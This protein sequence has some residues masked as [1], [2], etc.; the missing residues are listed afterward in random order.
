[1]KGGSG[2]RGDDG[3]KNS[4]LHVAKATQLYNPAF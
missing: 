4:A 1:M 2:K 3:Q